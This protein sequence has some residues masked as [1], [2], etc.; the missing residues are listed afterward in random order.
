MELRSL[1][2]D[3]LVCPFDRLENP[4]LMREPLSTL[5]LGELSLSL[6]LAEVE[7]L[8]GLRMFLSEGIVA[9][10]EEKW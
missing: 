7:P 3:W 6:A 8:R 10:A 4:A 1:E 2:C 5:L 9:V